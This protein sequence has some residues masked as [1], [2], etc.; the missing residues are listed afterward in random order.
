MAVG[1][2]LA[3]IALALA[4]PVRAGPIERPAFIAIPKPEPALQL[5]YGA[6]PSQ[7]IDIFLPAGPGPFPVA[8]LIH[9]GCWSARTAGRE[10]LRPLG[11]EL[12]RRGIAVWS[13]GYRRADEEGGGYPGTFQDVGDA[14]DRLR[15]EA[16][17]YNLDIGRTVLVGHSAGG[18]L[19][20]WAAGRAQLPAASP[21]RRP[22][23]FVP[24]SVISLA[25]IG[26]LEAFAPLVPLV[27]GPGI[28]ERLTAGSP[29]GSQ[30]VYADISPAMLAPS[31]GHVVMVSGVLDRLVPPYLAYDYARAMRGKRE[32]PVELVD[33]PGAGHV[34]LVTLGTP[35]WAEVLRRIDAELGI[36]R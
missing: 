19:A 2:K 5:R 21:L 1:H 34:D 10:Q 13:L 3:L 16:P 33:V 18:H 24:H 7:A 8:V 29:S 35:A 22:A 15:S 31:G 23:P 12:A 28:L 4:L 26:D 11:A 17:R 9:G 6:A 14:I 36:S 32:S 20:L 27:C 25:G 30:D